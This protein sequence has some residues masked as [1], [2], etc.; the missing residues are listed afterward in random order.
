MQKNLLRENSYKN[1][2]NVVTFDDDGMQTAQYSYDSNGAPLMSTT[3]DKD[4][5]PTYNFNWNNISKGQTPPV[6]E[7]PKAKTRNI[8]YDKNLKEIPES[9]NA[10][11]IKVKY[12]DEVTLIGNNIK[13]ESSLV[14]TTPYILMASINSNVPRV[15]I[16]DKKVIKEI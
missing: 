5:K 1:G 14:H 16:K 7:Q 2:E 15:Y 13:E 11:D 9:K 10:D 3:F 8:C 6:K 4:G 12:N